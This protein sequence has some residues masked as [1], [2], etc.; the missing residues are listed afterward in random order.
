MRQPRFASVM[1]ALAV[2]LSG[3]LAMA[4]YAAP[5][6]QAPEQGAEPARIAVVHAAP[7]AADVAGTNVTVVATVLGQDLL[8]TNSFRFGDVVPYVT[9]PAATYTVKIYAGS[10]SLP[11]PQGTSPVYQESIALAPGTDYTA[12]AVG[13]NTTEYPLDILALDDT[14]ALPGSAF[15][16]LRVLHAAPFAPTGPDDTGVDVTTDTNAPVGINNLKYPNDTGFVELP[17]GTYDLQVVATGTTNQI[18]NIDPVTLNPGDIVTVI[19]VGTGSQAFPARVLLLPFAERAPARVRL[20]HAAPFAADGA[21]VTVRLNG[22]VLTNSFDFR[23]ITPYRT[24]P[25]GIYS[26][27][28]FV[29]TTATG[30]PALAGPLVLQDGQSYTVVAMGSGAAPYPLK[31]RQLVDD[32]SSPGTGLRLRVLHAAPFAPTVPGTAVDVALQDGTVVPGLDNIVYDELRNTALPAGGT[33][34]LKV[35]PAGQPNGTPIID[36][37]ALT[38]PSGSAF[39]V[40]A[41]GGPNGQTAGLLLLDDL[42]VTQTTYL[43]F[44][45]K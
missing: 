43:P 28:I 33:L 22:Q 26:A 32:S 25:A 30:T 40:I 37:G 14:T 31:L 36:P 20:V 19:A 17:T 3:A 38:L 42:S 23:D 5:A 11:I 4:A 7:F 6:P 8:I 44:I 10:L 45:A 18:I 9:V 16:K 2:L 24:V 41:V 39:T 15:A 13:T 34:D 12:V 21:T 1:L 27:E 29:G 35:V